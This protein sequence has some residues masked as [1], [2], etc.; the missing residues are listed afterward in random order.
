MFLTELWNYD[1]DDFKED[2]RYDPESDEFS[3]RKEKHTR[4]T[5]LTL[6]QINRM[7]KMNDV[8]KME[9]LSDLKKI[10]KQFGSVPD[11]DGPLM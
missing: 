10:R 1:K 7:R 8:R 2:P 3:T 11:E 6:K 5:R 9:E 4:K